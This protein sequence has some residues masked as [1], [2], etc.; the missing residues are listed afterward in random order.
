MPVRAPDTQRILDAFDEELSRSADQLDTLRVPVGGLAAELANSRMLMNWLFDGGWVRWGWP[1][2]V[3]GLGGSA[4]IRYEILERLALRGYDIPHHLQVLEVLGPV[5]VSHAPRLAA[6]LLPSALRGDELWCQGFSEPEA[7]SD[8]AA[9]RTKA[10]L[11]ADRK[12]VINGQKIWTSYG[13]YA[14][15]MM[16]LA[17]TGT[18]SDRHRGMVMLLVD[19]DSP[20]IERRPIALASGREELAEFFFT[21][22]VVDMERLVGPVGSGW[23]VAM[24]LL[25]YERGGYAWMRMAIA[26]NRLQELLRT[27]DVNPWNTERYAL[28]GSVVG[29]AYLNLAALRART[30]ATLCRLTNGEVVGEQTSIDKVLLSTAEQDVFDACD[31]LVGTEMLIGDDAAAKRWREEWWYSRAASIYGG[32][33]E[34]QDTI[35]ADKMMKLPKENVSGR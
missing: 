8:L 31:A 17:R 12:F 10:T 15:R 32:A 6:A 1:E 3:G 28:A 14:D 24:D 29:R 25:Q 26:T 16:M 35:I 21:D 23:S 30:S 34:I 18:V 5:V 9:L 11:R 2:H 33:R 7:G 20:G 22:V 19:L 13:A 4:I 27:T